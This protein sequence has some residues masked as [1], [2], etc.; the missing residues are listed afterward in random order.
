MRI[1]QIES[2]IF[3]KWCVRLGEAAEGIKPLKEKVETIMNLPRPETVEQLRRF[4]GM[5]NFY[6]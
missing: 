1:R 6:R 3:G 4:L 2:R 5:V